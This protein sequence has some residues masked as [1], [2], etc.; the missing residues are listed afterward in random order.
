M[1]K[2]QVNGIELAYETFGEGEPIVLIMGIGGQMVLWDEH[3]CRALAARGFKVIR[4]DNRDVGESS[5]LD[6][7]GVEHPRD[8]L[9]KR[10]LGRPIRPPYTLDDM[11]DDTAGLIEHLGYSS[12]HVVGMSL[13]GMVAQCLALKHPDRVRSLT[14]IM[15]NPGELWA[16]IPKLS[17]YMALTAKVGKTKE[18]AIARQIKMFKTIGSTIHNTP[19]ERV[20]E[21]AALHF[22]RGVYPKGF[23]RQYAALLGSP[24]RLRR[25]HTLR[26]PTVVIHG[27]EDPLVPPIGG[28]LLAAFIPGASF[29]LIRGM[30]HDLGPSV[31]PF[32]IDEIVLNSKRPR[33]TSGKWPA[34][35]A[36][37]TRPITV[38]H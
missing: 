16:N 27:A 10:L 8:V 23:A 1:P 28:R 3:F 36:L 20:A 18:A 7:L 32:V 30:G 4:F 15:T 2:A 9:I 31:W 13:G 17:A 38:S 22:E 11:A 37:F 21:I 24:S 33:L 14:L 5:R 26:V 19:E 25:L 6:H 12:A 29:A 34:L 35:R